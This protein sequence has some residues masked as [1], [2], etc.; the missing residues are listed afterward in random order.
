VFNVYQPFSPPDTRPE[1][2]E[3]T[4]K[5]VAYC[6]QEQMVL[7]VSRDE[8]AEQLNKQASKQI[9]KEIHQ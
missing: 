9:D 6:K 2:E 3:R 5:D 8:F 4:D 1:Q 7:R